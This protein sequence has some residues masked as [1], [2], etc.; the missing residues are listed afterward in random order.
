MARCAAL[1]FCKRLPGSALA[2]N[3]PRVLRQFHG[4]GRD[5]RYLGHRWAFAEVFGELVERVG[6]AAG[7]DFN[8]S[9]RKIDCMPGKTQG[10][11]DAPSAFTKKNALHAAPDREASRDRHR[12]NQSSAAPAASLIR[13]AS[14]ALDL[15]CKASR[16]ATP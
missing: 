6:F 2:R 3:K 8:I 4:L 15:A 11:G 1:Y 14:I 10:L 13:S 12:G 16:R 5:T 9:I 7:H